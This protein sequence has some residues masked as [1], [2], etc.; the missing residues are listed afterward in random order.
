MIFLLNISVWFRPIWFSVQEILPED[1]QTDRLTSKNNF[2][3]SRDHT[4]AII[5]TSTSGSILSFNSVKFWIVLVSCYSSNIIIYCKVAWKKKIIR[6]QLLQLSILKC[7]EYTN[8]KS[9]YMTKTLK[10]QHPEHDIRCSA[11]QKSYS[12]KIH[13][14][15]NF[16]ALWMETLKANENIILINLKKIFQNRK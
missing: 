16:V 15:C 10:I 2:M 14:F 4:L 1:R 6:M 5:S 8:S 12:M 13:K 7:N 11:I 3:D 9:G